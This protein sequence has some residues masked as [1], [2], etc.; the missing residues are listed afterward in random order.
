[1][2][3]NLKKRKAQT[4][5][6]SSASKRLKVTDGD[7]YTI[8]TDALTVYFCRDIAEFISQ[9]LTYTVIVNEQLLHVESVGPNV[10]Q[11]TFHQ[12]NLVGKS[13]FQIVLPANSGK[14]K[15]IFPSSIEENDGLLITRATEI[16]STIN[17]HD[18]LVE[19]C[20]A[21]T[22]SEQNGVKIFFDL[23]ILNPKAIT[24]CEN[25]IQSP[26]DCF[27]DTKGEMR[28][29]MCQNRIY[30]VCSNCEGRYVLNVCLCC[31]GLQEGCKSVGCTQS[32]LD[33]TWSNDDVVVCRS[34]ATKH[35]LALLKETGWRDQDLYPSL[36]EFQKA[37]NIKQLKSFICS[38]IHR[39]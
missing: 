15:P 21:R 34:C 33:I 23:N 16:M 6:H 9:F 18:S 14:S 20:C 5:L 37:K 38:K 4:P 39:I 3:Q 7:I 12:W 36:T 8:G 25:A 28:P 1:M 26:Q 29:I 24:R 32:E 2:M 31:L 19:V 10:L 11:F 30:N 27:E 13:S 35:N 22:I 17:K